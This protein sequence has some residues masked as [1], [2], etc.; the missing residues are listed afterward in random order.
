[1]TNSGTS[2]SQQLIAAVLAQ[3]MT[4]DVVS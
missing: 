4:Y 3:C 1:M 2:A